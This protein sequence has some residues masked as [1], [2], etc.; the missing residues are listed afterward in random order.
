[1]KQQ[2]T[3]TKTCRKCHATKHETEFYH[4]PG[5]SDG[6]SNHCK[7]CY[8]KACR[9]R[10]AAKKLSGGPASAG[11]RKHGATGVTQNGSSSPV[12]PAPSQ[13]L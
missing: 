8:R 7:D 11:T 10:K 1:M 2:I 12:V 9:E 13:S 5:M 6:R 3:D 4:N